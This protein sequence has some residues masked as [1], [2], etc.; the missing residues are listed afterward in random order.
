MVNRGTFQDNPFPKVNLTNSNETNYDKRNPT[1]RY[2][3][4]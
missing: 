3:F 1:Y 2:H 4:L